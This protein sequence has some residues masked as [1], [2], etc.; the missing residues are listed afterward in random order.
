MRAG[1]GAI[2]CFADD[3]LD[4]A[5]SRGNVMALDNFVSVITTLQQRIREHGTTL[6]SSEARTRVALIDP[7][8]TALGWDVSDPVLVTPEYNV[9][10]KFADY[11]LLAGGTVCVFL[12]AKKLDEPLSKH[13]SQIVA[14]ASE[15]GIQFPVLTN[16]NDWEVYDN[17][18]LVPIEERRILDL[19]IL[20]TPA[21]QCALQLLLLWEPN[22]STGTPVAA[23]EPLVSLHPA[24][25]SQVPQQ[26]VTPFPVHPPV[27]EPD[28]GWCRLSSFVVNMD[29]P[30]PVAV[31]FPNGETKDVQSWG[32]IVRHTVSWLFAHA[33]LPEQNVPVSSS[34]KR[35]IVNTEPVHPAG[36]PFQQSAAVAGTPYVIESHVGRK[37]VL[38]NARKLLLHCGVSPDDV[39]LQV[40][41]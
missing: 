6:R 41:P 33:L 4:T 20:G 36:Q 11:A 28:S 19:S 32:Y 10:G 7:L 26:E 15:L 31:R 16:G 1:N 23:E 25:A 37:A 24:S 8:L 30:A 17:S 18:K 40:A 3:M 29:D 38:A 13:R 14:Y 12:E 5:R 35:Y 22:M 2:G 9:N 27:G 34:D 21:H 39:W